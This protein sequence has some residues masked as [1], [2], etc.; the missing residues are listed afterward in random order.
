MAE[1]RKKVEGEYLMY[2]NKPLVREGDTIIYGDLNTDSCVLCLDIM[3]YVGEGENKVPGKVL[4][5][6]VDAKDP[7]KIIKQG[8]KNGLHDAFS[9][10]LTWL[11][12]ELKKSAGAR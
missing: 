9:L 3:N 12:L 6:V 5:Q 7:N 1:T 8:D 4:I 11:E 2:Q 10:G